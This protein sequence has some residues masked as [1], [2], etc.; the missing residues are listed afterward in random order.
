MSVARFG[1]CVVWLSLG[2]ML[3]AA[4]EGGAGGAPGGECVIAR[5]CQDG[6]LC[7]GSEACDDGWC[8]GGEAPLSCVV[9]SGSACGGVCADD[10]RCEAGAC[11]AAC[12][13]PSV[14]VFSSVPVGARFVLPPAVEVYVAAGGATTRPR[15]PVALDAG[16]GLSFERP[17]RVLVEAFWKEST[18]CEASFRAFYDV[19]ERVESAPEVAAISM[20]DPRLVAWAAGF[21]DVR[22]GSDLDPG[23][24][25]P[26]RALGAAIGTWDDAVSLGNG[27]AMTF[28][29]E[30]SVG[31]AEGPE[32]AVFENG[33]S[34]SFLELAFV[35][36][37]SNGVDFVRFPS[38]SLQT[39][40]V[41]PYGT[42][43]AS[44]VMGVAGRFRAG[45]GAAF[46]LAHLAQTPEVLTGRVE[47]GAIRYVRLVDVVGDGTMGD[48]FGNPIYDPT[49]TIGPAGFDVEAV[50]VIRAR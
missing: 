26:T 50:G 13:P 9:A 31:D 41:G 35:E 12:L 17:G 38:L 47:L 37:S 21:V 27:G 32:L 48:S 43:D 23:W 10:E 1:G 19:V 8:I 29:F 25:D 40:D 5:D 4:C 18:G 22:W 16:H 28:V 42:L 45:F 24:M 49:P 11:E 36:V 15:E 34:E 14:P 44:E 7:N 39:A 20:D 30:E 6:D 46:D 3:L 2:L 33:F